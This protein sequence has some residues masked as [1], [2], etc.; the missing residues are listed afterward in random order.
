MSIQFRLTQVPP[1]IALWARPVTVRIQRVP[2][3]AEI[4]GEPQYRLSEDCNT[5]S[6]AS[7]TF[8]ARNQDDTYELISYSPSLGLD[9]EGSPATYVDAIE[10]DREANSSSAIELLRIHTTIVVPNRLA[11]TDSELLKI[12]LDGKLDPI[13]H[14]F[15]KSRGLDPRGYRAVRSM[16][17]KFRFSS[18]KFHRHKSEAR[19]ESPQHDRSEPRNKTLKADA[20]IGDQSTYHQPANRQ[21]VDSHSQQPTA[22]ENDRQQDFFAT[23]N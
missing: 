9:A 19:G 2:A 18:S 12:I 7:S 16:F 22:L 8:I 3:L 23:N 21:D 4:I 20:S 17:G 11:T 1:G 6:A 14:L 13:A 15:R 5:L 10:I